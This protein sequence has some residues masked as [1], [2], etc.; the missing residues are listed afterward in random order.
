MSASIPISPVGQLIR[1]WRR[2]QGMSQLDLALAAGVSS[3]H[4]S[5]VETGRSQPSRTMVARLA[6]TLA[7]PLRERNAMMV[8]AGFAPLYRQ[9]E[10]RDPDLAPARRALELI[11]GSH[12]PFPAFVLDRAW[13][14]LMTNQAHDRLHAMTERIQEIGQIHLPPMA[15]RGRKRKSK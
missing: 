5:F 13:N 15:P 1:E 9:S 2:V 7:M 6:E 8:A 10:L 14:I 12:E 11:L 4:V 3:R